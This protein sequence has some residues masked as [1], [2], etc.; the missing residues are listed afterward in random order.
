[1]GGSSHVLMVA[2]CLNHATAHRAN[3]AKSAKQGQASMKLPNSARRISA[4]PHVRVAAP[5]ALSIP[6]QAA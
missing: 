2:S 4:T 1:M 3:S 5:M 6:A